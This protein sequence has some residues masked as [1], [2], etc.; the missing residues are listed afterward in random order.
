[1][2]LSCPAINAFDHTGALWV[3]AA[4]PSRAAISGQRRVRVTCHDR[5][6][7]MPLSRSCTAY[8]MAAFHS[9]YFAEE[10]VERDRLAPG[11]LDLLQC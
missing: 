9:Q 8:H 10:S 1:M 6:Q 3:A 5:A 2:L 11:Q 7:T 4:N